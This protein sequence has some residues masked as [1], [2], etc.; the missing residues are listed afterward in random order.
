MSKISLSP[1][2]DSIKYLCRKDKHLAKVIS[3]VSNINYELHDGYY[4]FL[5]HQIIEQMLSIKAGAKIYTQPEN[6]YA[7]N[8][9]PETINKLNDNEIS[10]LPIRYSST[11]II[12]NKIVIVQNILPLL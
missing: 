10:D 5:I 12:F 2:T 9:C 1:E 6:L 11:F 7:N 8:I 4:A 3:M